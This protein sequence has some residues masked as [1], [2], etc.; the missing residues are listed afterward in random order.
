MTI[1]NISLTKVQKVPMMTE[2]T[3][4]YE[5]KILFWSGDPCSTGHWIVRYGSIKQIS[6]KL[7]ITRLRYAEL[8]LQSN[9]KINHISNFMWKGMKS[10]NYLKN[11]QKSVD[12]S[13]AGKTRYQYHL[14][15]HKCHVVCRIAINVSFIFIHSFSRVQPWHL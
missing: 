14:L 4:C 6:L 10:F 1:W 13:K 8:F 11:N 3:I 5:M 9:K 15:E 2:S 7:S 12:I